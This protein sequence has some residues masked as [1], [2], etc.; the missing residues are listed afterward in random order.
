MSHFLEFRRNDFGLDSDQTAVQDAFRKFFTER[1][2]RSVV[3]AAEPL[4]YDPELWSGLLGLGVTSMGL[5]EAAGGDSASFV[6]LVLVAEEY[7][8]AL[9]PV[10]LLSQ[11]VVG[12]LLAAVDSPTAREAL[13]GLVSGDRPVVLAPLPASSRRQLVPDAAL[14]RDVIVLD[15]GSLYLVTLDAPPP[16]V[17]NQGRTPLAWLEAGPGS[18]LLLLD[19]PAAARLHGLALAEWRL[20]T[21]AALTG[22]T[23]AALLIAVEFAKTRYTMGVSI[24]TLQGV[25]FPLADI[26]VNVGG[27]RNLARKAA[28]L[29]EYEPGIRPDLI[30]MAFASAVRTATHGVAAAVHTHGGLGATEEA[31][32]SLYFRRAKGWSLP[33]GDADDSYL[34]IGDMLAAGTI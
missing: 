25:S 7:G 21:A 6:D 3:R 10:P 14:A 24:G 28:W 26:A 13:A 23:E 1:S 20:L 15:G 4:G 34:A 12:R 31:D 8:S 16:H 27:A 30:S 22:L 11:V 17:P 33:L 18:R 2:P 9:A 19:G 29:H 5:P 32:V